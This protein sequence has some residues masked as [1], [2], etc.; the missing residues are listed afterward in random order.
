MSIHCQSCNAV[1]ELNSNVC[2]Y[3]QT[4]FS[5]QTENDRTSNETGVDVLLR[6]A[7]SKKISVIK[8]IRTLTGLELIEVKELVDSAPS[9]IAENV[10]EL[11]GQH[12]KDILEREGA[13]IELS[14]SGKT[15]EA[16]FTDADREAFLRERR[17]AN[18]GCLIFILLPVIA[19]C[20]WIFL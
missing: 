9:I 15:S 8:L 17:A 19:T 5:K 11:E 14:D 13:L 18:P 7:G 12:Y 20:L 3:C 10:A 16:R 1:L 2:S 4:P 6:D